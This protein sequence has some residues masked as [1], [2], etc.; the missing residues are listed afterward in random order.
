MYNG[1]LSHFHFYA[2]FPLSSS[3]SSFFVVVFVLINKGNPELSVTFRVG[4][5]YISCG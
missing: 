3:S 4:D 1:S 2:D 5:G